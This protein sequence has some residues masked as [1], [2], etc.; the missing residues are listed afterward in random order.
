MAINFDDR[1]NEKEIARREQWLKNQGF[2]PS[3]AGSYRLHFGAFYLV[4]W[5]RGKWTLVSEDP[6]EWYGHYEE[7]K[8]NIDF[9]TD[10]YS[11]ICD[12]M[13]SLGLDV[14]RDK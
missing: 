11:E 2:I 8:L 9:D 1:V 4:A 13:E 7:Q 5:T 3:N 14:D 6:A 10:G 12:F